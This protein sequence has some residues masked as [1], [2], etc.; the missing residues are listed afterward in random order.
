MTD[1]QVVVSVAKQT[2]PDVPLTTFS[3]QLANAKN[4]IVALAEG[5]AAL[6]R[7]KDG[8]RVLI[9]N[10]QPPPAKD[11]IGRIKFRAGYVRNGQ[12]PAN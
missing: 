4:D 3:V 1:S 10:V 9:A 11:D 8:D 2:P 7:L 12:R 6:A 5:T